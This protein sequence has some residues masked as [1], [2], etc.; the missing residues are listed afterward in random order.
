MEP[1]ASYNDNQN[2][3]IDPGSI[4]PLQCRCGMP[5]FA[6]LVKNREKP[7]FGQIFFSCGPC[8]VFIN[9]SQWSWMQKHKQKIKSAELISEEKLAVLDAQVRM[10]QK[11][12]D[13]LKTKVYA[14]QENGEDSEK[15]ESK[16]RK[17]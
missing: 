17:K 11:E 16:K 14:K 15:K 7:S 5:M 4:E 6:Q 10:L 8:K 9:Q 13:V 3:Y 2:E 12:L 1:S